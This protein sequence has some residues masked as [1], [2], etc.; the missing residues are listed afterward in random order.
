MSVDEVLD[1]LH[2]KLYEACKL[3]VPS[4]S[5]VRIPSRH[6]YV[7]CLDREQTR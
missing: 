4:H 6:A 3:K 1:E 2:M 7:H 5:N